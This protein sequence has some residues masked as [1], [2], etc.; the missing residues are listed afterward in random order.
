MTETDDAPTVPGILASLATA[1]PGRVVV[2]RKRRGIWLESTYGE[3]QAHVMHL[4]LAWHDSGLRSGDRALI[5]GDNCPEWLYADLA[6]QSIGCVPVP[7]HPTTSAQDLRAIFA[8]CAPKAAVCVTRKDLQ[9]LQSALAPSRCPSMLIVLRPS[10]LGGIDHGILTFEESEDR[11]SH[12]AEKSP[13]LYGSL[14]EAQS[15]DG[16]ARIHYTAGSDH[17][18]RGAIVDRRSLAA[19]ATQMAR[20]IGIRPGDRVLAHVP[21]AH[22]AAVLID[23]YTPLL[24]GG[25]IHFAESTESIDADR[26]EVR[27]TLMLST[28]V[29]LNRLVR[30]FGE[31]RRRTGPA[32][33]RQLDV[34]YSF[35]RRYEGTGLFN[36]VMRLVASWISVRWARRAAGLSNLRHLWCIESQLCSTTENA[37]VSLGIR[38]LIMYGLAE[39][40]G[41]A[42]MQVP[43]DSSGTLVPVAETQFRSDKGELIV[44][45]AVFG[46]YLGDTKR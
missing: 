18:P 1:T 41:V 14:L 28:P 20:S 6:L 25:I 35:M 19:L 39:T 17:C 29:V 22:P 13:L 34:G 33:R 16:W 3:V 23:V 45:N 7:L 24:A 9:R 42:F 46:G 40:A 5:F 37:L 12:L 27:P 30:E 15:G 44:A 2:R 11:G 4:A 43:G 38:P 10:L 36:T 32:R 31:L 8:E 21:L 26:K